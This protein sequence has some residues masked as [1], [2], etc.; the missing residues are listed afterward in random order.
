MHIVIIN[1]SKAQTGLMM[2]AYDYRYVYFSFGDLCT[3]V[4]SF[5]LLECI[6]LLVPK[7]FI[8]KSTINTQDY[9]SFLQFSLFILTCFYLS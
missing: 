9:L 1:T 4:D 8:N 7:P 6:T 5:F 2:E 3:L